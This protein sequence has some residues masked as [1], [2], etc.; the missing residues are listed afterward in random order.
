MQPAINIQDLSVSFKTGAQKIDALKSLNLTLD[1]R[2]LMGLLGPNG[3]GKT[4]LIRCLTG[5]ITTQKGCIN[6]AGYGK[7]R[8]YLGNMGIAFENPGYYNKLSAWEY[9]SFFCDLYGLPDKRERIGKLGESFEFEFSP[10]P[11]ASL[12]A[13]N[14]QKVQLIRSLLHE[15]SIVLWDEPTNHLDPG[16]QKYV[17]KLLKDYVSK[18]GAAAVIATHNLS[19]ADEVCTHFA[20]LSRGS[21]RFHGDRQDIANQK[22]PGNSYYIDFP[23]TLQNSQLGFLKEYDASYKFVDILP[24]Q[25]GVMRLQINSEGL[26]K[27]IPDI[28]FR[29]FREGIPVCGIEPIKHS[30]YDIYMTYDK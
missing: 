26:K 9:L 6:I 18:T 4:T 29:F 28:I 21:V 7:G 17:L 22:N 15:P 20:F 27:I 2:S 24:E 30:L 14:K 23:E 11:L 10:K 5:I 13:G 8:S 25:A 3:S 1:P 16:S 19:L 12:S